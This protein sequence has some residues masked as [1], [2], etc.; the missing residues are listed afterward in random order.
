[1]VASEL[2]N[3]AVMVI[4]ALK[5]Q[6]VNVVFGYPGGAVLPL[7]DELFKQSDIRHILVRHEQGAIH[8]AQGY[9]R[10]TG[11][12]GVVLVTSG[13]GVTNVVTGLQDAIMDSTPIVCIS[14]QV[15]TFLMGTDAFQEADATGITRPCTKYS[16]LVKDVNQLAIRM[17]QAFYIAKAGRPGPV[18]ID[19]PKDVQIE[20]GKY[21]SPDAVPRSTYQPITEP[22]Q[23][24]VQKSLV[25]MQRAEKPILYTGGGVLNSGN[26]AV[27]LLRNFVEQTGFPVTST[28][29][30]L[31]AVPA[32]DSR[33]LGMLGMHGTYEANLAMHGADLI[34][35]VGA[36]FDDRITGQLDTFAPQAKI[37]HMDIN[38]ASINK[39]VRADVALVG[40]CA[41]ILEALVQSWDA[42]AQKRKKGSQSI[43]D[44]WSTINNWRAKDC[45]S[46]Q[47]S[48]TVIKPQKAID[49]LYE[50]TKNRDVY[51]TTEVG[52]HQMWTAQRYCFE[53]PYRCIT[54]G[55]LGTMGF[56]VPAAVGV[57]VAHPD[58]LVI[59][60]AGE[61]SFLMTMQEVL[62]AVQFRLPIKIFIL[63]NQR[64]GMVRQWQQL[65]YGERYSSS[66]SESL[67]DFVKLADALGCHGIRCSD[68]A[69]LD[70]AIEE[71]INIDCPVIFDCVVEKHENCYPMIPVGKSHN[72]M[73]LSDDGCGSYEDIDV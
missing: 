67:P 53:E 21:V 46:F 40:D 1:M 17:H 5:D 38:P 26:R 49:C 14:G 73:V 6:D 52:Q 50:H 33:F 22:E 23:D 31:G 42:M 55:G 32:S 41:K 39:N 54:S 8:A 45:L 43:D 63:N 25:M 13:P 27:T 7:Y 48:K 16:W 28:L 30:G 11:K 20:N 35:S 3:G 69:M 51:I 44:W 4:R 36:R 2:M 64:L 56:G 18:L 37:I 58:S 70:D 19:I 10:S 57:Q 34:I 68:P 60:I 15:A 72:E 47:D 9:A 61:A 71:M 24:A 65:I 66:Y 29:M 12:V 59:D 62:T